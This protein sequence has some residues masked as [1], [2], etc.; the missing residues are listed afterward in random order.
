VDSDGDVA[1]TVMSAVKVGSPR[2]VRRRVGA[3]RLYPNKFT[4][5]EKLD[6]KA[7]CRRGGPAVNSAFITDSGARDD[8]HARGDGPLLGAMDHVRD[9]TIHPGGAERGADPDTAVHHHA[10]LDLDAAPRF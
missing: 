5:S 9:L 3:G 4:F 2:V 1:A 6:R 10:R 7:H 8:V